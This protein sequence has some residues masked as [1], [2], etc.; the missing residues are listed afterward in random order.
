LDQ[1][2]APPERTTEEVTRP[3]VGP[4]WGHDT[5]RLVAVGMVILVAALG[6]FLLFG[7]LDSIIL[8][9]LIAFLVEPI[10]R[11]LINRLHFRPWLAILVIYLL[12]AL[13][14]IGGVLFLPVL[15]IGSIAQI[16]WTAIMDSIE[17][18][19]ADVAASLADTTF[20]GV[21]LSGL[22]EAAESWAEGPGLAGVLDPGALLDS[23]MSVLAAAAGVVGIVIGLI[24]S[25]IFTIILAIYLSADSPRY[26]GSLTGMIRGSHE[27]EVTELGRRLNRSWND[28]V[29]GQGIMV[30][31]IG[32]T[33]FVVVWLIGVPGALFLAVIA[34]LLEVIPTFGPIIATIPAVIIALIQ[35]STRFTDMNHVLFAVI[36]IIAY[37]LIQ[38]LESNIVAPKVMGNSVKLPPLVVLVSI[39]AGFQVA[40]VLG[41]ILAVPVVANLKTILSYLWAKV[42]GRDPW[43]APT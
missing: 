4:V 15:I 40:G 6:F 32:F 37:T 38:Q 1:T 42:H 11:W 36:V 3:P 8:A 43:V 7:V 9:S 34:G 29:R 14:A 23:F 22:T 13:I 30:V 26:L 2:D 28:Y 12:V 25:I 18:W 41:A 24:S 16:D 10:R 21:D 17:E 5:R 20:L 19:I 31:V 33:T 27:P 35:G 39:T